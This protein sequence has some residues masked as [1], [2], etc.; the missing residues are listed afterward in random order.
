M[1][2]VVQKPRLSWSEQDID[3]APKDCAALCLSGGGFRAMVFHLGALRRL[4][5]LGVLRHFDVVSSVSGGSI[6]AAQLGLTWSQLTFDDDG[7]A[8][9]L[10]DLVVEPIMKLAQERM[11]AEVFALGV[12]TPGRSAA[13]ELSRCLARK[14]FGEST[15][16][17][18]PSG[19]GAP[20]FVINAT[21]LQTG[22]L[23]EFGRD[24]QGDEG[25]GYWTNPDTP[26]SLA[27]AASCAF[28]PILSPLE[29]R[30]YGTF[31]SS[32]RGKLDQ[33]PYE[34][35]HELADGGLHDNLGLE[36][37]W[38]RCRTV[39][40]SD[41]GRGLSHDPDPHDDKLRHGIRAATI[42]DQKVRTL[43]K[44]Q[45]VQ[46]FRSADPV[47]GRN[48]TYWSIQSEIGSYKGLEDPLGFTQRTS[49][50]LWTIK[51][52]LQGLTTWQVEDL[53][54]WGYVISD[55]A[56][57]THVS[58]VAKPAWSQRKLT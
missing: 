3:S 6:T 52:R 28:P 13:Q 27:V 55:A 30:P 4:N 25:V 5:E 10:D 37:A 33:H 40:I 9:N 11:D 16:Q 44:R 34:V 54:D 47:L 2:L 46:G 22:N 21:S 12:V 41:G 24:R 51:T 53:V 56:L 23:F 17:D 31:D 50:P 45:I 32:T 42:L 19:A 49:A 8:A 39:I 1:A 38:R 57:R 36:L 43:R 58:D 29:I 15:L 26:I 35:R 18:F 7:V 48:G 20:E 14:L